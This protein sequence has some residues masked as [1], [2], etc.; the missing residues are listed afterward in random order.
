M[1]P[2]AILYLTQDVRHVLITKEHISPLDHS[3]ILP[4]HFPTG[5][6]SHE[7]TVYVSTP[8]LPT[9]KISVISVRSCGVCHYG[10][11]IS[12][13]VVIRFIPGEGSLFD[14]SKSTVRS[15]SFTSLKQTNKNGTE[16][17]APIDNKFPHFRIIR[18][19]RQFLTYRRSYHSFIKNFEYF[20]RLW[21][22][23]SKVSDQVANVAFI[24]PL[25][26]KLCFVINLFSRVAPIGLKAL[27]GPIIEHFPSDGETLD[28]SKIPCR[29][30]MTFVY[31]FSDIGVC[32]SQPPR[33]TL[34]ILLFQIHVGYYLRHL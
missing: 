22:T 16:Y 18:T 27:V 9:F 13:E 24:G 26:V 34:I 21:A 25:F 28:E 29:S 12:P 19:A 6:S 17:N 15:D 30:R 14:K 10:I 5:V 8:C 7:R 4:A 32:L 20:S 1:A 23:R 2:W 11:L 3:P 33:S 31:F